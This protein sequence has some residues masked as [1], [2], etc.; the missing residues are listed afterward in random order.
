MLLQFETF[1]TLGYHALTVVF[2]ALALISFSVLPMLLTS[3]KL[4]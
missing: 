3:F 1:I 4:A 2:L